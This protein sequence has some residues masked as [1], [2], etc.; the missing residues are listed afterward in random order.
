MRKL[1]GC[2]SRTFI[3]KAYLRCAMRTLLGSH[4]K[5][6]PI[7]FAGKP[8]VIADLVGFMLL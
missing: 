8:G 7:G 2:A 6:L 1:V 5:N 3:I 4:S